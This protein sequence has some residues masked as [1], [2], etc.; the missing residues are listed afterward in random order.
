MSETDG[1]IQEI[2]NKLAKGNNLLNSLHQ[3]YTA[4]G[5][6]AVEQRQKLEQKRLQLKAEYAVNEEC[7]LALA[8]EEL[9]L[10]LVRGFVTEIKLQAEDE[11]D[12]L[13]LQQ[14]L[15]QI[16]ELFSDFEAAYDGDL[17]SGRNF[18]KFIEQNVGSNT[19][20]PIYQLSDIALFQINTLIDE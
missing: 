16:N 12:E 14:S 1:K 8:A 4:K 18:V 6:D 9:P 7:L 15:S 2:E 10:M 5:G 19:S 11:H 20:K 3:Q 13:I 17:D